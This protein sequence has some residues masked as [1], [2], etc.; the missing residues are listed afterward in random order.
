MKSVFRNVH[1]TVTCTRKFFLHRVM[2]YQTLL[3]VQPIFSNIIGQIPFHE[4]FARMV[5]EDCIRQQC[6]KTF[7]TRDDMD[8]TPKRAREPIAEEF[9]IGSPNKCESLVTEKAPSTP[10]TFIEKG[11]PGILHRKGRE[12]SRRR[13]YA[14][15][16]HRAE[17]A[18][19]HEKEMENLRLRLEES[20]RFCRDARTHL[21]READFIER[22][23]R[24]QRKALELRKQREEDEV[25]A[26]TFRPAKANPVPL[27]N[28]SSKPKSTERRLCRQPLTTPCK[29]RKPNPKKCETPSTREDSTADES[30]SSSTPTICW[31]RPTLSFAA[32]TN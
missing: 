20:T 24:M 18:V 30:D 9:F 6:P 26:C 28:R 21:E 16:K 12:R 8:Y 31:V 10:R 14:E 4:G 3:N 22:K 32:P 1:F 17:L 2:N 13:L 27:S 25:K 5:M 15:H 11:L 29:S 23:E 19:K 7:P